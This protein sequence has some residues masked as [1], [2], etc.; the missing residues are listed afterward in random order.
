MQTQTYMAPI[1]ATT[2]QIKHRPHPAPSTASSKPAHD[3]FLPT[4]R[5]TQ[6]LLQQFL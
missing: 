2:Q 4:D 1:V 3:Q 5:A 6:I